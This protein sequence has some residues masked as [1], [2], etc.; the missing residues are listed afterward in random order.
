MS[1]FDPL[2]KM[3]DGQWYS[4]HKYKQIIDEQVAISY[5]SKGI[6][7][8]DT[9]ELSPFDR[10]LILESILKIKDAEKEAMDKASGNRNISHSRPTSRL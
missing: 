10:K 4:Q 1:F 3:E 2:I 8:A 9:D 6:S 7:I 5:A